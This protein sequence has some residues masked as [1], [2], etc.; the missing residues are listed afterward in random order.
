MRSKLT[1]K[2]FIEKANLV[3]C[4]I[5]DYSRAEYTG[6]LNRIEIICAKH[7]TFLQRP[8]D[9]L[10]K[11]GC[12]IC[13]KEKRKLSLVEFIDKSNRIHNNKYDYSKSHYENNYTTIEII[14]LK[15]GIFKQIPSNHMSGT[16]CPKCKESTGEKLIRS[17]LEKNEINFKP[18]YKIKLDK[19][20]VVFD[21]AIINDDIKFIEFNGI[22][23]YV[24][25]NF[26][27]K[28]LNVDFK[29]LYKNVKSDLTKNQI[30]QQQNISLLS[31]PYWDTKRIPDLLYNF[32]NGIEPIFSDPPQ[33]VIDFK[34]HREIIQNKIKE[35]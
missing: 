14:C 7:G 10:S 3:H 27:S 24:P 16:G 13:K 17:Y 15:H 28:S 22:Q 35:A 2:E 32:L 1:T 4:K 21:F 29:N 8:N 5:Y 33:K 11:H 9:H 18:Q 30:C 34:E 31:I 19:S 12:P 23:H 25:T 6:T 26:G 20:H